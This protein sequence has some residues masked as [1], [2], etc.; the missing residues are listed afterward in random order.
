MEMEYVTEF[1]YTHMNRHPK[2][3]PRNDLATVVFHRFNELILMGTPIDELSEEIAELTYASVLSCAAAYD[4]SPA[5]GQFIM[6]TAAAGEKETTSKQVKQRYRIPETS[7][8]VPM[9]PSPWLDQVFFDARTPSHRTGTHHHPP[10]P[11]PPIHGSSTAAL[12]PPVATPTPALQK[13]NRSASVPITD[14]S[15]QLSALRTINSYLSSHSSQ[16]SLKPPLPSAKDIT[17]TLK[18][19]IS[20]LEF[21]SNKLEED[22][23]VVLKHLNCPIKLNKS[24]LR[25]PGTPHSWPNLLAELLEKEKC[26]LEEDVKKFHSMIEQL[27]GH[28]TMVEKVLE[29]KEKELEAKVGEN[30]K[31]CEENEELKKR[32]DLQGI[33]ARDAERMKRELQAVGRDIGEAEVARNTWEE[34]CWDLDATIGNKFKELEALSIECNQTIKREAAVFSEG[35]EQKLQEAIIQD[36]EETQMC[37]QELFQLVDSVS[38][39]K[40]YMASKILEMKSALSETVESVSDMYKGSLK[41]QFDT[42]G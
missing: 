1:H 22:L 39:Y 37:A 2:K 20:R 29:E 13:I 11:P 41:A 6:Y 25:A 19:V 36:E 26:V 23:Y 31:I 8:H 4:A 3:R 10:P 9:L 30:K 18:F 35:S 5:G 40:E 24:A 28:I 34:K 7:P 38:K 42:I 33:N 15:Y 14:R 12:P 32:V 21:R 27:N 16:I 17:E